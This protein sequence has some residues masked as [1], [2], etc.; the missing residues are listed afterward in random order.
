[1]ICDALF[2]DSQAYSKG[3]FKPTANQLFTTT[4]TYGFVIIFTFSIFGDESLLPTLE[5]F[6]NYPS[7]LADLFYGAVLQVIGQISIYYVVANFKQHVFPL[8]STTRK[9]I[10]VIASIF[11]FGHYINQ[12]QWVSIVIVFV[13]MFYELYEELTHQKRKD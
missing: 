10:T 2:S 13:G 6:R 11:Y 3:N 4:N 7:V 5:F 9:M 8:I 1:V 12:W